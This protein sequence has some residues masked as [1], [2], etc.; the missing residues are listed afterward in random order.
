MNFMTIDI[1]SPVTA[2]II[3]C[4]AIIPNIH[5]FVKPLTTRGSKLYKSK[6]K[7]PLAISTGLVVSSVATLILAARF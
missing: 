4:G 3:H 1:D 6:L 2:T 7:W 5:T